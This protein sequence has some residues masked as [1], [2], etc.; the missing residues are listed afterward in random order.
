[1]IKSACVHW[2]VVVGPADN[3]RFSIHLADVLAFR[4]A[5]LPGFGPGLGK[6]QHQLKV[7]SAGEAPIRPWSAL[8]PAFGSWKLVVPYHRSAAAAAAETCNGRKQSVAAVGSPS[9]PG[10]M[11]RLT[12]Q[13]L[14]DVLQPRY[15]SLVACDCLVPQG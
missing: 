8:R 15:R 2:L 12:G 7:L 9:P 3:A 1:M 4:D 10:Q 6:A 13:Q 5:S 14:L 11:F